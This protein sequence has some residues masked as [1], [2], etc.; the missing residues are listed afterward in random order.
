MFGN[1]FRDCVQKVSESLALLRA[2]RVRFAETERV[3]IVNVAHVVVV[4]FVDC[5]NDG[6]F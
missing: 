4:D 6:K 3:K 5:K 1:D 2:D